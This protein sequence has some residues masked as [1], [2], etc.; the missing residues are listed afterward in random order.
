MS[1]AWS[2]DAALGGA[3][4]SGQRRYLL[5]MGAFLAVVSGILLLLTGTLSTAFLV[6]PAL[7]GLII[8]VLIMGIFYNFRQVLRL[9]PE[10]DWIEHVRLT[11]AGGAHPDQIIP[12]QIAPVLLAPMAAMLGARAGRMVLSANAT[13]T[14]LDSIFSRLDEAREISRYMVGLLIFLG[15][16][17]TFWGLINTLSSIGATIQGLSVEGG[18]ITNVFDQLKTGLQAPLTGMG[19]AFSSSLFGLGGS[20]ILGFLDLNSGQAQNQFYNELEEWLSGLTRLSSGGALS[21]GDTAMPVYVTALLEQTADTV[22]RLQSI[23]ARGEESRVASNQALLG[24]AGQLASLTDHLQTGQDVS[25][26]ML[27]GQ[28]EV[29][30]LLEQLVQQ[31]GLADGGMD[32]ASRQHLRNIDVHLSRLMQDTIDGRE[33]TVSELRSDIKLLTRTVAAL[34]QE[35]RKADD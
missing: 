10:C 27:D 21:E 35:Q 17:G 7:N 20:L 4:M 14:L 8:L 31:R 19:T 3:A 18:D 24:L 16:L 33:R 5:R 25:R 22:E 15:L 12:G 6:N 9:G 11:H 29:R 13:R 26:R 34:A 28:R 32:M 30:S 2:A 23:V 1:D